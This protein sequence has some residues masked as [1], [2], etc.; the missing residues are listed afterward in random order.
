[1]HACGVR[2]RAGA[3][4]EAQQQPAGARA[5]ASRT[6]PCNGG[7]GQNSMQ[8]RW[9]DTHAR[10][11]DFIRRR[12]PHAAHLAAA[13]GAQVLRRR[14]KAGLQAVAAGLLDLL[15]HAGAQR[16]HHDLHARAVALLRAR[17]PH[18]ATPSA[19]EGTGNAS[20]DLAPQRLHWAALR[21]RC[22]PQPVRATAA[23]DGTSAT[24]N[25]ARQRQRDAAG[26]KQGGAPSR[27]TASPTLCPGP[28]TRRT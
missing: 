12:P 5:H 25:L 10:I 4:A 6:L 17:A 8:A 2:R 15:H 7:F 27:G 23:R 22:D 9:E 3:H 11:K 26:A 13:G 14:R 1:M 20:L 16:P 19:R 24:L 18:S 28:R 21:H